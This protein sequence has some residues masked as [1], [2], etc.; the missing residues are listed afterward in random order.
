MMPEQPIKSGAIGEE[1]E[2]KRIA[3]SRIRTDLQNGRSTQAAVG[4]EY[5]FSE[6]SVWCGGDSVDR[7]AGE[8]GEGPHLRIR[9]NYWYQ[10]RPGRNQCVAELFS[11]LVA[12]VRGTQF[13][14]GEASGR[15]H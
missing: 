12:K 9:K 2:L 1:I 7:N 14:E 4:K 13:R 6:F 3:W 8:R 10:G 5:V 11:D 15:N